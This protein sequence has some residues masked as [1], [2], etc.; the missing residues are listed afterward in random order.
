MAQ[1]VIVNVASLLF[2][3]FPMLE[4]TINSNILFL[5]RPPSRGEGNEPNKRNVFTLGYEF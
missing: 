4:M 2:Y 3:D 5:F 1:R